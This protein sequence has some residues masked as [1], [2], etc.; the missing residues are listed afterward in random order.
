[1]LM[2]YLNELD[3]WK[4]KLK[5]TLQRKKA[6]N[7]KKYEKKH[8]LKSISYKNTLV[9]SH[10]AEICIE[11]VNKMEDTTTHRAGIEE[12]RLRDFLYKK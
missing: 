12:F 2:Q 7:I 9:K 11:F 6:P 8:P 10:L 3:A 5:I 4:I 1:M